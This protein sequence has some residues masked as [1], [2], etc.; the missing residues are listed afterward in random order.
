MTY[1]YLIN[2][3]SSPAHFALLTFFRYYLFCMDRSKGSSSAI[4]SS[5]VQRIDWNATTVQ[6]IPP[7][8][9]K[10]GA[11]IRSVTQ[12][13][14]LVVRVTVIHSKYSHVLG[15][16][17]FGEFRYISRCFLCRTIFRDCV[18]GVNGSINGLV[19]QYRTQLLLLRSLQGTCFVPVCVFRRHYL[20]IH[21]VPLT[22]LHR[23]GHGWGATVSGC[24]FFLGEMRT[25]SSNHRR[26][27]RTRV[28]GAVP[29]N[30]RR[31]R[32]PRFNWRR[33][34]VLGRRWERRRLRIQL[35]FVLLAVVQ[36][37]CRLIQSWRRGRPEHRGKGRWVVHTF[38]NAR[39]PRI[40]SCTMS[41]S[42]TRRVWVTDRQG[43]ILSL[44]ESNNGGKVLVIITP[45]RF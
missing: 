41:A 7:H 10:R 35:L 15:Q 22:V 38:E 40:T 8:G 42:I 1:N 16:V 32:L 26:T 33:R 45:F 28:V 34:A 9:T 20:S 14:V 31:P 37:V 23:R 19:P 18:H 4:P 6:I 13:R 12:L 30:Y 17:L 25:L 44:I 3:K 36:T 5:S 11:S 21:K 27:L 2:V 39:I 43:K 29:A 24:D